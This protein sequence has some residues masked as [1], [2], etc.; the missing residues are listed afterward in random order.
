[1]ERC[2]TCSPVR[3]STRKVSTR[4]V[5][6]KYKFCG[7]KARKE[8]EARKETTVTLGQ[9]NIERETK[10]KRFFE[11]KDAADVVFRS[12]KPRGRWKVR[13]SW[14]SKTG[15]DIRSAELNFFEDQ[16]LGIVL[17]FL[18]PLLFIAC[19]FGNL[20]NCILFVNG[21]CNILSFLYLHLFVVT[22][23]YPKKTALVKL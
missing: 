14:L 10:R 4:R 21:A 20:F 5:V 15:R 13:F 17:V 9:L 19:C 11:E 23:M 1:M 7:V 12:P 3:V 22:I 8:V 6:N 18:V 2:G 16:T